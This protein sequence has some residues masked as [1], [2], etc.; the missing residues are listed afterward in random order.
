MDNLFTPE[1]LDFLKG[2][3]VQRD[4]CSARHEKLD[5]KMDSINLSQERL[6]TKIDILCKVAWA[7]LAVCIGAVGASVFD[8]IMQ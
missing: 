4:T 2:M 5:D 1:Q 8:L 3:F 6:S 7:I